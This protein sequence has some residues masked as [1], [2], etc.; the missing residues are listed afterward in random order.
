MLDFRCRST[1]AVFTNDGHPRIPSTPLQLFVM[2]LLNRTLRQLDPRITSRGKACQLRTR[3][4][5]HC[6]HADYTISLNL[7]GCA[8]GRRDGTSRTTKEAQGEWRKSPIAPLRSPA[9][10]QAADVE[11]RQTPWQ[12]AVS[13]YGSA[14]NLARLAVGPLD[15]VL[16]GHALD[17]LGVHVDDDVLGEHFGSLRSCRSGVAIDPAEPGRDPVGSHYRILP[18]HLVVLPLLGGPAAYPFCTLNHLS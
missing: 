18:P 9:C 2:R 13:R 10:L 16:G 12:T 4:R 17:G 3:G 7:V 11:K 14:V 5:A 6:T 15:C 1:S 8:T